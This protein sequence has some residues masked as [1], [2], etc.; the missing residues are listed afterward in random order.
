MKLALLIILL[1]SVGRGCASELAVA[2]H[3]QRDLIL[4]SFQLLVDDR[5][6][7]EE[8]HFFIHHVDEVDWIFWREGRRLL[9]TTLE[10]FTGDSEMSAE[11]AWE[12]RIRHCREQIDLD[13]EIVAR[14]DRPKNVLPRDF[15][16]RVVYECVLNGELVV[17]KKKPNK[18]PEPT[19]GT[20]TPRAEPR[21]APFPPVAHL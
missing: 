14:L 8:N 17:V 4:K 2:S 1:G 3:P 12:F 20:V 6:K 16:L 13:T 21:G 10:P 11:V 5:A 9:S 15:A 18:A 19:S 7:A